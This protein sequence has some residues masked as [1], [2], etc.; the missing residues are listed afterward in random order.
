MEEWSLKRRSRLKKHFFAY[1]A[2][3]SM[4]RIELMEELSQVVVL[5]ATW[6]KSIIVKNVL[7]LTRL[8]KQ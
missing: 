3:N 7:K 6:K 5:L 2:F 4:S 1:L 8:R